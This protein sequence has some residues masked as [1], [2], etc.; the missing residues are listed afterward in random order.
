MLFRHR[1][2]NGFT[3]VELL[4]VIAIIGILIALLLPAVQAARE[5]ARRIS[6]TSNLKQIGV[7]IHA[8]HD[9]HKVFPI[10]IYGW[11]ELWWMDPAKV[12]DR[13]GKGWTVG[14]LPQ[15]EQQQLFDQFV[16]GFVG[17]CDTGGVT[18]GTGGLRNPLC[19]EAMKT[20]VA[21]FECPS[22]SGSHTASDN[23]QWPGQEVALTN[24]KGSFGNH[25]D[26]YRDKKEEIPG[27]FYRNSYLNPVSFGDVSDGLT[28]T[29]MVGE[30]IPDQNDYSATFYAGQGN[31]S[32]EIPLN[33][34]YEPPRPFAWYDVMGFKSLHPGG[35]NFA[36][37]DGSIHFINESID[38]DLY[39]AL[40]TR[41]G[42]E[43]A[44]VPE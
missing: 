36:M 23:V 33:R 17:D 44:S 10:A 28:H 34:F 7:A 30:D 35:A 14:I 3:L 21:V 5:A 20:R 25:I 38:Y 4:V 32:T 15:L 1:H 18:T 13:N 2:R 29:F 26:F 41:A 12:G 6:C 39:Q 19:A 11:D 16:P 43:M 24:Y 9:I 31:N 22:D 37:A 40:S 8:Y 42:G 27:I